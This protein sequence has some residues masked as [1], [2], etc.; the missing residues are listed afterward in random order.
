MWRPLLDGTEA[1]RVLGIVE[2][3]AADL[4]PFLS[5]RHR[6]SPESSSSL[7]TGLAGASLFFA[8]LHQSLPGN[9]YE[10]K[11]IELLDQAV[12]SLNSSISG[13]TLYHGF[14]GVAWVLEHLQGRI[15]DD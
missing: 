12:K 7:A 14:A 13:S 4:Y 6:A 15:I 2:E 5:S 10:D 8:Y 1:D 11:A 3:I 9:G